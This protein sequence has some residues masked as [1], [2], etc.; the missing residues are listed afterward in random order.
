[1]GKVVGVGQNVLRSLALQGWRR[2]N[3]DLKEHESLARVKIRSLRE[4]LKTI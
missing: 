1:M 3:F 2:K 4:V